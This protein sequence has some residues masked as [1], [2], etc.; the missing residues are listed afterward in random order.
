MLETWAGGATTMKS[1][2]MLQTIN[3]LTLLSSSTRRLAALVPKYHVTK[4]WLPV[5]PR[6]GVSFVWL[7]DARSRLPISTQP[8][9]KSQ[10]SQLQHSSE[11]QAERRPSCSRF[12][13]YY[14]RYFP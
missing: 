10:Q 1:M 7:R 6:R 9:S 8:P 3:H 12:P 11:L 13:R 4:E 5:P 2:G 14:W